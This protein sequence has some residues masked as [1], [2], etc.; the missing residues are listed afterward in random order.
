M[1]YE[2]VTPIPPAATASRDLKWGVDGGLLTKTGDKRLAVYQF[3]V[4]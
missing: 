1:T 2:D 4:K 3:N